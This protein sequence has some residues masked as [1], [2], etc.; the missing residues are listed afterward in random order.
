MRAALWLLA[1][2]ATA[3]ATALFAG[4]NQSTVTLF[5]P[6]YRI[7]LSLNLAIAILAVAF[8]LIYAAL[9]ATA[10]MLQMPHQ[11]KRWRLQQKERS[12]HKSLLQALSHLQAGRFL[13]ARKAALAALAG[14]QSLADAREPIPHGMQLRATAH[15]VAADACHALQD[16]AQRDEQWQLA[17]AAVPEPGS[18][19]DQEI[20]EGAQMRSARWALDDRDAP[21]ALRRLGELPQG[22]ARR[23]IALRI[24]LKASRL[25]GDMAT[26]LDTARLLAKHRAFSP[27]ASASVVR[28]LLLANIQDARD[29][30]TLQRFWL[31]LDAS[32]REMP[33]VA[34]PAAERLRTLG[35]EALQ[36]R[37]WLEP[38]WEHL[39]GSPGPRTEQ[40]L[41]R[42][43]QVLESCLPQ[44]DSAWLARFETAANAHPREPRLQ[45]L[46]GMAC[47]QR[48]LWGKAQQLLTAAAPQLAEPELRT[49]AW[50]RLALMAEHRD[51]PQA[52]SMAWRLAAQAI[53]VLP[54]NPSR[55]QEE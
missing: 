4:N 25:A 19:Q 52:A 46:A 39:I 26:A 41:P 11:A 33:E 43:V 28:S 10:T 27:A 36:A 14:A 18:T 20:R 29:V 24:R 34:L 37:A 21:E 7:D 15:L 42:L 2:F 48:Q 22:A 30:G 13:R 55:D 16:R 53:A 49:R 17:L 50:Q 31:S 9:R 3:V 12:T 47:V 40:F 45:Y 35:G 1:L 8:L 5:W 23:T 38:V 44:L 51:D 54:D 6:P 32:E